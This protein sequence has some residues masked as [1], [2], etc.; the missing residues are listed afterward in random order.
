MEPSARSLL[1]V[2]AHRPWPIPDRPWLMRQSWHDVLFAHWPV[3]A[4]QLIPKIPPGIELDRH[5]G[6]AW[7]GIVPFYMTNVALRAT[8][9]VPGLSAFA[10]LNVR[11]YVRVGDKPGVYFFS[12][13][14]A[15]AL[16]VFGSLLSFSGVIVIVS[17]GN[18]AALR[19]FELNSGDMPWKDLGLA[20][21]KGQA[22]TFLLGG[23]LWLSRDL[24]L[25]VEPG[26]AFHARSRGQRPIYN[27]MSNTGTMVAAHDGGSGSTRRSSWPWPPASACS[28]S[29][30]RRSS[31]AWA[32]GTTPRRRRCCRS[33][34][35]C[36][37]PAFPPTR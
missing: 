29:T 36:T 21:A 9:A 23:R 28:W 22:V 20:P 2:H 8:P 1:D 15:S 13:D 7:I 24:D 32:R 26:T 35:R 4:S 16:A 37:R 10:E 33:S 25:W 34:A 14:A 30:A 17:R 12:L 31:R 27:P 5:Q 6:R 19:Q 3:D 18:L 11:T